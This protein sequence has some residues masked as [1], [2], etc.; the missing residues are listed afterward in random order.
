MSVRLAALLFVG[1]SS[2]LCATASAQPYACQ[3][4]LDNVQDVDGALEKQG[5]KAGDT[6][7]LQRRSDLTFLLAAAVCDLRFPVTRLNEAGANWIHCI[8]SGHKTDAEARG[9]AAEE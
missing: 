1:L 3:L 6:L 4:V 2:Q 8:Y 9:R 5:C 7:S